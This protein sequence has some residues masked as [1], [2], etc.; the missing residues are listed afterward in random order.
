MAYG[1]EHPR[2]IARFILRI[3][4]EGGLKVVEESLSFPA[5]NMKRTYGCKTHNHVN[6]YIQATD[7]CAFGVLRQKLWDKTSYYASHSERLDNCVYVDRMGNGN[8]GS[9]DGYNIEGGV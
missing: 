4:H 8:E 7:S 2:A 1:L 5:T 6:G 3:A 9:G